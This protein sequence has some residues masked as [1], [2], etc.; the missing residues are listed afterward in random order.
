MT[1]RNYFFTKISV[2]LFIEI[3]QDILLISIAYLRYFFIFVLQKK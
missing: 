2:S 1:N 3:I